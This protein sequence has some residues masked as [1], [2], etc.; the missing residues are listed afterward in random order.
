MF[1]FHKV[2]EEEK[3]IEIDLDNCEIK[4]RKGGKDDGVEN[5][6]E[7]KLCLSLCNI[8]LCYEQDLPQVLSNELIIQ[9]MSIFPIVNNPSLICGI[10]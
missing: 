3:I 8:T 7:S 4:D 10:L 6:I 5:E 1:N 2:D 9:F